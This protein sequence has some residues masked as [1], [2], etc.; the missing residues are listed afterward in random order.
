MMLT[1]DSAIEASLDTMPR[2]Q[3]VPPPRS[4][5]G[6]ALAA[7]PGAQ[8]LGEEIQQPSLVND[9]LSANFEAGFHR[10]RVLD[11]SDAD[12]YA[13]AQAYEPIVEAINR[14]RPP[15]DR[16]IN[17]YSWSP[18]ASL[19]DTAL[20]AFGV[21]GARD[22]AKDLIWA[23]LAD[24]RKTNPGLAGNLPQNEA[25]LDAD[26]L[27]EQ[28]TSAGYADLLSKNSGM[29]G[30]VAQF[31]G[32][33]VGG[34]LDPLNLA[35]TAIGFPE[36]SVAKSAAAAMLRTFLREG[37]INASLDLA[38]LPGRMDR[39]QA[40]GRPYT[41]GEAAAEVAGS[42]VLGGAIPAGVRGAVHVMQPKLPTEADY[43]AAVKD[44]FRRM[45]DAGDVEQ[46]SGRAL[47]DRF[48][49]DVPD[50][51]PTA[52]TARILVEDG[53]QIAASNPYGSDA[54]S[55]SR[56]R[57]N[58]LESMR[59]LDAGRGDL[60]PDDPALMV[61]DPL[62]PQASADEV[63]A[64]QRARAPG[65]AAPDILEVPVTTVPARYSDLPPAEARTLAL[66]QTPRGTFVNADT[67]WPIALARN[68]IEKSLSGAGADLARRADIVAALPDILKTAALDESFPGGA[69]GVL[70][71][72][73]A[74][75]HL[76][77]PVEL[78]GRRYAV[79]LT[80]R[81]DRTG[82]RRQYALVHAEIGPDATS[83]PP[84]GVPAETGSAPGPTLDM[85][86]L[87]AAVKQGR[88]RGGREP[89]RSQAAV[90]VERLS[91]EVQ[92]LL[93]RFGD[94]AAK[95]EAFRQQSRDLARELVTPGVRTR[96]RALADVP[97]RIADARATLLNESG[98]LR[99]KGKK[100]APD[101][102]ALDAAA[103]KLRNLELRALELSRLDTDAVFEMTPAQFAAHLQKLTDLEI[104]VKGIA[105]SVYR[106]A[107]K[108]EFGAAQ[109]EID[110]LRAMDQASAIPEIPELGLHGEKHTLKD[111]TAEVVRQA[112]AVERLRGC[113]EGEG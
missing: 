70:D 46:L 47:L 5:L 19:K 1:D 22:R 52:R 27:A 41:A 71:A 18:L 10:A 39:Y 87:R 13:R 28:Q 110:V 105:P 107:P 84:V 104:E 109:G 16:V 14:D 89:A 29:A 20:G 31:A 75:H 80:V 102:A 78:A 60:M 67:G 68:G 66:S 99:L 4:F 8:T 44:T 54:A 85:R 53:E 108:P 112:R 83:G 33:T 35:A 93:A 73:A 97:A 95:P 23:R 103:Q 48:D 42:F 90:D 55:L 64:A 51:P 6:D 91:P 82:A 74:T 37:A 49:A 56:H 36:A 15:G 106:E 92:A 81:E 58:L 59:A 7:V 62:T 32:A 3:P 21:Q 94:P 40:I 65:T 38:G 45:T 79:Q 69:K 113:I 57:T 50:P 96:L 17:P 2:P 88:N 86:T 61:R 63:V 72:I 101:I 11:N 76:L 34:F 26:I 77:A 12:I 9:D 43:Q 25:E 98:P 100:A 24:L 111:A 30:K